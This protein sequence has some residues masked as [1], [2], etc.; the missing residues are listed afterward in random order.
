MERRKS[1]FMVANLGSET[2]KHMV[3]VMEMHQRLLPGGAS[4][5]LSLAALFR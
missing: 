1:F 3:N 5:H 2:M 4:S